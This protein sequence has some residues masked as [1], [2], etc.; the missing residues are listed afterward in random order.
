MGFIDL[1]KRKKVPTKKS[2]IFYQKQRAK[3][4]CAYCNETTDKYACDKHR[5][6]RNNYY[7]QKRKNG[8]I[9]K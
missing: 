2:V 9:E 3:G 4:K 1:L 8:G 6:Y 7:K 5:D